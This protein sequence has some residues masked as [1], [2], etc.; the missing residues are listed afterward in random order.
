[1]KKP[2]TYFTLM[3]IPDDNGKTFTFRIPRFFLY[4]MV[5]FVLV[6][7][8]GLS[9]LL[10]KSGEIA[11]RLQ[12]LSLIRMENNKLSKENEELRTIAQK[13]NHFTKVSQYLYNLA[14]PL[15]SVKIEQTD[16]S[17]NDSLLKY[18][19]KESIGTSQVSMVKQL[20]LQEK[21]YSYPTISPVNGWIT[22]HFLPDSSDEQYGHQGIDFAAALGTPIKSTSP[23][24]VGKIENDK[25]LGLIIT[26]YHENGIITKYGHCS[27]V[28][29]A[30][31][32]RVNRGQTIALVGNTGR[33]SAPHLH[34][35]VIKNSK[36]VDPLQY[37][38]GHQD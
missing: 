22:R 26:I 3:F 27:Q 5:V 11:A 18:Q 2:S 35:E 34:Y 37:I 23:G 4:S 16:N 1:M 12:L 9:V 25:Y 7:V 28:L 21:I 17:K 19:N 36:N 13:I 15:N 20:S 32:E 6:I 30:L 24:V 14:V 29:V 8:S 10:F 38:S 31:H 33:S